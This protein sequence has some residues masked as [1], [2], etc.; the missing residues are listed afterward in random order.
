VRELAK[1][2]SKTKTGSHDE[3]ACERQRRGTQQLLLARGC[4]FA[5]AYVVSAILARKL[6]AI[7]Y[8]IYGVVISQL[9][10]LE[11]LVSA[12]VP[13]ATCKL[14]A[15]GRHDVGEVERSA[16]AL[17]VGSSLLLVG[18]CWFLAPVMA[19]FM[20]IPNGALLL[21]IAIIDVPFA[22]VYASYDGILYGHRRFG[23]IGLAQVVYGLT[24]LGASVVLIWLGFSIER[25]LIGN[26]IST[27]VVCAALGVYYPPTGCLPRGRIVREILSIAAPMALYL[28]SVQVLL[29]LDLWSL[30]ILWTGRGEVVG[31]YVAS[32]NL[33]RTLTVIPAVQTGV[34][35]ASVAWALASREGA[36]ARLHLQ[37]ATRFVLVISAGACVMVTTDAS[38]ILS[39]LFSS[40]Y[41]EGERFLPFQ[42]AA[43]GLF[44]LLDVFSNSLLA[45]GRRWLVGGVLVATIPLVWLTNYLLIPL[46]GPIGAATSILV[47]MA[48]ATGVTGAIVYRHFGTV[49]RSSTMFRVL[50]AMVTVGLVSEAIPMRGPLLI[51]KL[52]VLGGL[53]LLVL[54]ISGEITGKDFG[55]TGK[56]PLEHST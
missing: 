23:V 11:S 21:R 30:K 4:F 36:R 5:S 34:L 55:L 24:K 15:S 9:L 48:F 7:D 56:R 38:E 14:I 40:A 47:G 37:E 27:C 35:F 20:H 18:S 2:I 10:W 25:V 28:I 41:A 13:G 19:N 33:A 12:G 50:V 26:V 54:H 39:I 49:I 44:G 45:A 17:L 42:F 43:F 53:Y 32:G 22:V 46:V 8:G 51:V 6:G 29:N 3:E 1:S 52:G 16:R 31:Q